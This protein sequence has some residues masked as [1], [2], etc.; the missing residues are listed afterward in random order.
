[1]NVVITGLGVAGAGL[2]EP[3][4]LLSA[5]KPVHAGEFD[6]TPLIGARGLRYKDRATKLGLLAGKRALES[7][8]LADREGEETGV[9]VSSNYGNLDTVCRVAD[10]IR[11]EGVLGTSPMDLPNAS[12]NVI[13]SSLAIMF[14]LRGPN[15]MVCNG[16]TSGLDAMHWAYVLTASGRARRVLVVGVEPTN[17]AVARLAGDTFD[18]AA[19]LVVESAESARAR[20]AAALATVGRY[21]HRTR[22]DT[23]G[24]AE[25]VIA[26]KDI[27]QAL[28]HASG[29]LG[30]L[31]S[32]AGV[33]RLGRGGTGSVLAVAGGDGHEATASLVL[34]RAA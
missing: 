1:M 28:G 34:S 3:A 9:V 5:G 14:G 8:G 24:D 20:D 21:Q 15:L 7:A 32:V 16:Q 29:A 10:T 6:P 18:G 26:G 23:A 33:V 22:I 12:S 11:A 17:E 25:F 19:A 31:Q 27:E 13:A 30:V 2:D 4:D